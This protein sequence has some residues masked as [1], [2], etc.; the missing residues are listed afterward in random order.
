MAAAHTRAMGSTT[1]HTRVVAV[2]LILLLLA[3]VPWPGGAAAAQRGG[4]RVV[5]VAGRGGQLSARLELAGDDGE[6]AELG[7][8]VTRLSL[9][10]R[11][12]RSPPT[13]VGCVLS[14]CLLLNKDR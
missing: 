12:V 8:D 5:S 10:A 11:Q 4:Y 14:V 2:L 7:P 3:V 1:A 9:T 6:K 13:F